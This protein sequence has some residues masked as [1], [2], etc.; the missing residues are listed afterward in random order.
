[1]KEIELKRN[2]AWVRKETPV[3]TADGTFGA[4]ITMNPCAIVENDTI[5]LFYSADST[6]PGNDYEEGSRRREIHLATAPL[7]DPEN[8]THYGAVLKNDTTPGSFDF[9]WCVLPHVVKIREGLYYMMYSGN[10]GH[11][12]G[13]NAFPGLG[14]AW[15]EDLYHWKKYEHN[16]VLPPE[17]EPE[18]PIVGIAGGG[19]YK[20]DTENGYL[21]HLFYTGCPTLG[22]N[23][24]TDQQKFCC[25]ATSSDGIHWE[26]HGAV[27]RRSTM[28]D[29]E[30]I[31]ST[32]GPAFRDPDGMWRHWYS[33]IGSRW[34]VYSI[35][36]A[37]STDGITWARGTR[38]G[39]NLALAPKV[40]DVG[41]LHFLP[42]KT[43]WQDQSVSYPCIIRV[44]DT[45]R[46]YYCGNDYGMGGIGTAV[47]APM[48]I[49]LTGESGGRAK[50]WIRGKDGF[51]EIFLCDYVETTETGIIKGGLHEEGITADATPFFEE[52]PEAEGAAPLSIRAICVHQTNGIRIDWFVENLTDR[53][54]TDFSV[55]VRDLPV[56]LT[57]TLSDAE[58]LEEGSVL[59]IFMGDLTPY[60]TVCVHGHLGI[61]DNGGFI[62]GVKNNEL[63]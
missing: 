13:L 11:G 42:W 31:A 25:Y 15:S 52:F 57:L 59:R 22:D 30:N 16:P 2:I 8:F 55:A 37:E 44:G 38:Y 58:V 1:M 35:A 4:S 3:I 39:E 5:Y 43:R 47:S 34:G 61:S 41:E 53:S 60:G 27:H 14:A 19:L 12:S 46:M 36:Y 20:E 17:G 40:R 63:F 49:S 29:Y 9:A 6:D 54:F 28:R 51:S 7:N 10:C 32:G 26:R 48:R 50:L 18:T 56:N 45:M 62:Q 23:V 21:L 24:F 33:A